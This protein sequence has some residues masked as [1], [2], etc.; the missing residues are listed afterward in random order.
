M[1][2]MFFK[3]KK[4]HTDELKDNLIEYVADFENKLVL[5]YMLLVVIELML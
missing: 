1:V 4:V 2:Y 3:K 5:V